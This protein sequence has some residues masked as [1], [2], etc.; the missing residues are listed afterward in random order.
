[1]RNDD[2]NRCA[3]SRAL[4]SGRTD[5]CPRPAQPRPRRSA[6]GAHL[7]RGGRAPRGVLSYRVAVLGKSPSVQRAAARATPASSRCGR[8]RDRMAVVR[9]CAKTQRRASMVRLKDRARFQA[10]LAAVCTGASSSMRSWEEAGPAPLTY[11]RAER[12]RARRT[13]PRARLPRADAKQPPTAHEPR[14]ERQETVSSARRAFY[15]RDSFRGPRRRPRRRASRGAAE[16]R[17]ART[18]LRVA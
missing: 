6:R 4:H 3:R 1:M 16:R 14:T 10:R 9:G 8:P 5:G 17:P 12:P 2:T 11:V 18:A 7:T 15:A 13:C